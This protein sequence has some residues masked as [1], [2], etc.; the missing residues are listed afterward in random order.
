MGLPAEVP[1]GANLVRHTRDF[2]GK[3]AQL[4][5]HGVDGVLQFKNFALDING[6]FL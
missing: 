3:R 6:D 4:V 2:G 1:F 5:H